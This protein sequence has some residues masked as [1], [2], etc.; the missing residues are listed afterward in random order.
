MTEASF[1]ITQETAPNLTPVNETSPDV[2]AEITDHADLIQTLLIERFSGPRNLAFLEAIGTQVQEI[3]TCLW[4]FQRKLDLDVATGDMLD[5]LGTRV[6]ELRLGK[7]D[8][9]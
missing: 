2:D 7:T 8:D 5:M 1:S 9:Q 3:E 4:D 6:S